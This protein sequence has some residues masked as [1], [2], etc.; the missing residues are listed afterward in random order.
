MPDTVR[1]SAL[2]DLIEP[3]A[4]LRLLGAG[5]E[6][7]EGPVWVAAEGALYFS[8]IPCDARWR[9]TEAGGMELAE[10]PTFKG[11]GMALDN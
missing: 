2:D 10:S 8:D 4:E 7:T 6:F 3:G 1:T 9:W 11:N 5:Y